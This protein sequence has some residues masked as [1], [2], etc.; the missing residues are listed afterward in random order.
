M[1]FGIEVYKPTGQLKLSVTDR[2]TKTVSVSTHVLNGNGSVTI[3]IPSEL[4]NHTNYTVWVSWVSASY[5]E[6]GYQGYYF[7]SGSNIVAAP[8][9]GNVTCTMTV[10]FVAY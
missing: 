2:I 6:K 9:A 8:Q 10:K 4:A 1:A 7:L 5:V 3:P